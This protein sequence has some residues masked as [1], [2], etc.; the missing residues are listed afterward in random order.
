MI[1]WLVYF[2]CLSFCKGLRSSTPRVVSDRRIMLVLRELLKVKKFHVFFLKTGKNSRK[3]RKF[4]WYRILIFC[5]V[6]HKIEIKTFIE[7]FLDVV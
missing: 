3:M 6:I 1:V 4:I 7:Y 5:Y 2:V